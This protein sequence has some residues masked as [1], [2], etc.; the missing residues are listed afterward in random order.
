MVSSRFRKNPFFPNS[1]NYSS[2]PSNGP[3]WFRLTALS[4]AWRDLGRWNDWVFH[5]SGDLFP[6]YWW[7]REIRPS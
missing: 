1:L 4:M 3:S 7:V 6:F 5:F 2:F